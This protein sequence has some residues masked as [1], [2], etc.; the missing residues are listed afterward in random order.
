LAEELKKGTIETLLAKSDL[1]LGL[2]W[3]L[4]RSKP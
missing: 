4:G 1:E 2:E 3:L